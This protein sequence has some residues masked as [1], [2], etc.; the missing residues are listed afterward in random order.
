MVEDVVVV[1]VLTAGL[2][3]VYDDCVCSAKIVSIE[4][5]VKWLQ[6]HE[7]R[8]L[9]T[10]ESTLKTLVLVAHTTQPFQIS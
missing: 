3:Y 8:L 7:K 6:L 9:S 5:M 10:P 4:I 2:M 1:V